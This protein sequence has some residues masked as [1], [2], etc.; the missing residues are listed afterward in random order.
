MFKKSNI[1]N[2]EKLF[3]LLMFLLEYDG[4]KPGLDKKKI[5]ELRSHV[6]S[7]NEEDALLLLKAQYIKEPYD[8]F[9]MYDY[10]CPAPTIG[11][12]LR[13]LTGVSAE[14]K[15]KGDSFIIS[16]NDNISRYKIS[17]KKTE[18]L[19]GVM[20]HLILQDSEVDENDNQ[21][22]FAVSFPVNL[23][24]FV[25]VNKYQLENSDL[26]LPDKK[27]WVKNPVN[28]LDDPGKLYTLD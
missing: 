20:N 26:L 4:Q 1:S 18:E 15:G 19:S 11:K 3:T 23:K 16:V 27:I 14:T 6:G 12:C 8:Q 9:S 2:K 7:I 21:F 13:E 22:V 5:D 17:M 25:K 28:T 10:L 24:I